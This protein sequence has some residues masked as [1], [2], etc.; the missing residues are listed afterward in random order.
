M[1]CLLPYQFAWAM[2]ASYDTHSA[3]DT[4]VHFGH[5]EHSAQSSESAL[6]LAVEQANTPDA[7]KLDAHLHLGC[8]QLSC[9]GLIGYVMPVFEQQASQ[10]VTPYLFTYRSSP[11]YQPE[12]P[13][14]LAA[15]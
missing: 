6:E 3:T 4:K 15:L 12:R 1:M 8:F 9:C 5:H 2:V 11:N 10:A 7:D 14:W 13:N